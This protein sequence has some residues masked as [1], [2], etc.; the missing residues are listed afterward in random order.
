[1]T[2]DGDDADARVRVYR[3][4]E[5]GFAPVRD[6]LDDV[7]AYWSAQ[8]A[9]FKAHVEATR[10][11]RPRG[12]NDRR[13]GARERR[14]GR[15]AA[16]RIR[17]LHAGDRPLVAA[18][19]A[20]SQRGRAAGH[21][22]SSSR[23]WAGG[24][25]NRST[26]RPRR[27]VVEIGR[28]MVWDPP[29][30]LAFSWR[31]SN[32]AP[33]ESTEVEVD[34]TPQRW[35]RSSPSR[36]AASPRCARTIPCATASW[37][38]RSA[39]RWAVG[40]ATSGVAA[41][42]RPARKA[43]GVASAVR[44]VAVG[45]PYGPTEDKK[46]PH[47][48]HAP[49]DENQIIAERRDKLAALRAQGQ[50]Y[51][52]DFRRDALAGDL[53]ARHGG[54]PNE[55]LEAKAIPVSVAGRMMLKRVM[56]KACFATL[57]DMSGRIQLYVTVDGVGQET[58][59]VV[60]ALGPGRHRRGHRHALQDAHRRALGQGDGGTPARE[61]AASAAREVP[62]HDGHGAALPPALRGP[63]HQ[64]RGAR[65]VRQALA[66][67]A[68]DPRVLRRARLPR[69]RDADDASDPGRR[70]R[71]AV[72]DAS[73][74][75]RHGA[76]PA[77]RAGAV[78]EEARRRRPREGVRDQP[79]LPQRRISTRAT[80]PSSRCSS[81]TRRIG[82]TTTSW[83]SPRRCCARWRRRRSARRRSPTRARRSTLRKP[84]TA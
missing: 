71:A 18:R 75:A 22:P 42:S 38:A 44:Y 69:G 41:R 57:Q 62:R 79:Q 55:A 11:P 48:R 43:A 6:W 15:A 82:T 1:M 59:D 7:E 28:V 77:H 73:Q 33:H 4:R 30:R 58:L 14:G 64:S 25:S 9:G 49:Q 78:P 10:A 47:D 81:S 16:P 50:A 13:P 39:R 46:L 68:G 3:V 27:I 65:R 21:D 23:V 63:H 60:Q 80:T 37:A 53:H 32:F 17:G 45:Y 24:S 70:R 56:G 40:G 5:A 29:R 66:D 31:A 35:A 2:E 61:G 76:L 34:F 52:N 67:R 74:R 20:L 54:E 12:R 51:P 84:S 19:R 8:L 83:T 26:A 72:R 36:T